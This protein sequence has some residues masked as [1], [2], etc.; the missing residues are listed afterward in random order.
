MLSKPIASSFKL[1]SSSF[2]PFLFRRFSIIGIDLGTTNSCVAVMEGA[3]P[4]VIENS[5][6]MRTTPS[7]VAF[8]DD[9]RRLVGI[10]AKRQAVTNSLNT[11][12]ATKR[13]IGRKF[14]DKET[15][16]DIKTLSYKVVKSTNGDAWVMTS[17]GEKYSPSQI[18]AFVLTKMKETAEEYLGKPVKEAII[19]VPAYFND[20]Q[21]QA[22]KDAGKI[23]GLEVKRIINEPTAAALA[24][25]MDK[26]QNNKTIA[27]YDL[28]GGTFD[29]SILEL[30]SG[31]F[32]VKATNGDTNLGGE[33]FDNR[34]QKYLIDIFKKETGIDVSND[35]MAL[36]RLKDASE[37]AKIE[38]SSTT[39]TEIE[40]P[41]LSADKTG[42][43]HLKVKI[44]RAKYESMMEDLLN[45]TLKPCENCLRDSGLTKDKINEVILVGGMT[46]MPKVQEMLKKFYGK[47][48]NKNANPDEAV[49]IGAAIQGG[50]L[51]GQVKDMLLLD[52]APLSLGI[53]TIGGIFTRI[54]NR[55]TTIPTKKSQIFS[56]A[57]DNQNSVV[58]KVYQGER[59]MTVDNK[60]LGQFDL[61]GI[62]PA[63]KGVPQIEVTFDIDANGIVHVSAKDNAS[64]KVMGITIKS[65]SGLTESQIQEML[66]KAEAMK[67]EDMKRKEII[68]MKNE[69]ESMIYNIEK[70]IKNNDK[71]L[72][73]ELK[74]T[75]NKNI[76]E[77]NEVL[78]GSNDIKSYDKI[79]ESLEKLKN[80]ALEIGKIL[81]QNNQ[82]AQQSKG[83]PEDNDPKNKSKK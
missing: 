49:A 22:T 37:K 24:Y 5:E 26:L 71:K 59:E 74:E 45:R 16:R 39:Q 7:I 25:G 14:D 42:P 66:K 12:Y 75:I 81:Y 20:S 40:L 15:Q 35:K 65:S 31:V 11:F 32:E 41:F 4:K 57:V 30:S 68:E 64:G 83:K 23:A 13:L 50:I 2:L 27:V 29:I 80:S 19:T 78:K 21:R 73:K 3:N 54:I 43:K 77:L 56:T 55:N 51:R 60:L 46:R 62:P 38:L 58:V 17:K 28:G 34:L 69:G 76:K 8:T 48:P 1:F 44:T 9:N 33:D 6:G 47:E 53:E 18:G 36:Q 52:V 72:P 61:N 70:Q 10:T 79:K 67:K 82:Q 63:P